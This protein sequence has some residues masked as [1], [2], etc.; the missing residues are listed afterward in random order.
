MND[1]DGTL[2]AGAKGRQFGPLG[3]ALVIIPTYNEA[4]NIKKIVGRVRASVPDAH[5]L[6]ADDNS[7]DGTGKLADE[8]AAED[9]HVQVLHRKGK[10]GLGA[11]YLAGF[12]WGMEHGYGVLVEMDADG[13]HQPEEL[14]RLLTALKGADLVLGSRW[15]PGGRVVNWP[16]SREFISRGGSMYSRLML[17]V[18]I[19]D[20]TGGFRAFRRETLEGLG[21]GEVASQ[22]YCFQVDLARRAVKSGFHVVEVPITFVERELGDSK[23]SRDIL[24]E[25]L[26][27]VT[28]W[29]VGERVGRITGRK[30]TP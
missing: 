12:A 24:V 27:R 23:M 1:G 22:G 13:S 21:L 9:D 7:P 14:P 19:R 10:E 29:G 28:T 15:V 26:W 3:T 4:E 30:R 16:K 5:V 8:L 18:P 20:V 2:A 17:D 6:V 11:A 25:A